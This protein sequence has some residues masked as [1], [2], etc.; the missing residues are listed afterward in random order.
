IVVFDRAGR[1]K[2][3]YGEAGEGPLQI[4]EPL[5]VAVAPDGR[6]FVLDKT[7]YKIVEFDAN[8]QPVRSITFEE[9]PLSVRI[10]DD[11]LFVTTE[12][13][14]LIG[15]LEGNLQT[16]YVERGKEPGQFD[17]PG[18]VAIGEDGTLYVAD[19]LNYRVQAIGTDG[20]PKWQYGKPVDPSKL[21]D[22]TAETGQL[23]GLPANIAI[24]DNGFLYV[25]DGLN[26]EIVVLDSSDGSFV[27]RI[28]D[29]GHDDGKFYY[30]DGIDYASGR[31]VIADK[32]NDRVEVFSIPITIQVRGW[33]PYAPWALLALP[34][35]LLLLLLR[36]KPRYVMTPAFLERLAVDPDREA[37]AAAIA[38]VVGTEELAKTGAAIE[39]ADLKWQVRDVADGDVAVAAE[40]YALEPGEAA[41]LLVGAGLRGRRVLLTSSEETDR[42]AADLGLT[43][44]TYDEL[45][46]RLREAKEA[47][48]AKQAAKAAEGPSEPQAPE[49]GGPDE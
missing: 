23:F 42:A 39:G 45:A 40:S 22:M 27:E 38:R 9:Y 48:A 17:R 13:G 19:S 29:V 15:D 28:G 24:D 11:S 7:K 33:A 25:V 30:P 46:E 2:T 3:T 14:V 44:L 32:Y 10:A 41:A 5:G 12:S 35:L 16:G 18:G 26:S 21:K 49:Q 47:D 20:K 31:L 1:Y 36:R 43:V 4:W 34:P 8:K 37:M 6:S